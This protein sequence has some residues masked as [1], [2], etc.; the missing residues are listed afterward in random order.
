MLNTTKKDNFDMADSKY[1]QLLEESKQK[2][3]STRIQIAKTATYEQFNLYW[4]F[5]ERI[6]DAQT[7]YGWG[8]SVVEQLGEDLGKDF[9]NTTFGFSARNLWDMRRFYI[10]YKDLPI[11]RQL[12]AE[13]RQLSH[14][15]K[16]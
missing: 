6:V 11:L 7:K 4:W 13:I 14:K 15:L 5:G 8:R 16:S 1:L 2:I 12:V 10:E 9:P 3:L